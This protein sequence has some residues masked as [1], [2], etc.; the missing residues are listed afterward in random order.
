[1]AYN[2]RSYMS[3]SFVQFRPDMEL[4][5]AISLLIEHNVSGGP[6]VD[7]F[8]SLVG[9]LSEVDCLRAARQAGYHGSHGGMVREHMRT[10]FKTVD[11]EDGLMDVA[12]LFQEDQHAYFRGFPV[13]KNNRVVGRIRLRDLL[14]GLQ[15]MAREQR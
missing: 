15:E 9:V 3:R 14:R 4:L 11:V 13:M 6:V 5:E 12:R 2:A 1:M 10:D 7:R 8:G